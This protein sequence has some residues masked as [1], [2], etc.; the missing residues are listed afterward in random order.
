[1]IG[2]MAETF[3]IIRAYFVDIYFKI[4]PQ[5]DLYIFIDAFNLQSVTKDPK[6]HTLVCIRPGKWCFRESHGHF[7]ICKEI[8]LFVGKLL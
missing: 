6:C 2:S 4:G 1:M 5:R 8:L 7:A 3:V